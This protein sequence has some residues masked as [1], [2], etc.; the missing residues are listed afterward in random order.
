MK[1]YL[2]SWSQNTDPPRLWASGPELEKIKRSY[3]SADADPNKTQ[4]RGIS[5]D[6]QYD[7]KQVPRTSGVRITR[8]VIRGTPG[9]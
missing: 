1:Y 7:G 6:S 2:G 9:R 3:C 8:K 5:I 4:I